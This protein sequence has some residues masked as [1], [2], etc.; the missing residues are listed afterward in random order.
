MSEQKSS[1]SQA[2]RSL[3]VSLGESQQAFAYR[4]KTAVRT[5]AR[6]ETTRPPKGRTLADLSR[7]A[8]EN[9]QWELSRI[10]GEAFTDEFGLKAE[11]ALLEEENAIM[12]DMAQ[13]LD[14]LLRGPGR[15]YAD[16]K[17]L[18]SEERA[19]VREIIDYVKEG[20]KKLRN[21]MATRSLDLP[22]PAPETLQKDLSI[23][24]KGSMS[25]YLP[26]GGTKEIEYLVLENKSP[27]GESGGEDTNDEQDQP[28]ERSVPK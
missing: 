14:H 26:G 8:H 4:M 11:R 12:D 13:H 25:I 17:A 22:K 16:P 24:G 19:K 3:R 18:S 20:L 27:S 2:V 23:S 15:P 28:K 10:F 5:I 7:L 9:N 21:K 6:W 1:V